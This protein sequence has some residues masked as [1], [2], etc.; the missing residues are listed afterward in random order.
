MEQSSKI[1]F[2]ASL[3]KRDRRILIFFVTWLILILPSIALATFPSPG[4]GFGEYFVR[5]LGGLIGT[6]MLTGTF[7]FIHYYKGSIIPNR[8]ILLWFSV[9]ALIL[10]IVIVP[11]DYLIPTFN[12]EFPLSNFRRR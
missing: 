11:L 4:E 2:W 5:L 9:L 7:V 10:T 6:F 12:V 8:R 3:E 1:G